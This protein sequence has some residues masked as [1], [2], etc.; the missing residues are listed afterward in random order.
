MNTPVTRITVAELCEC[1]GMSRTTLLQL[2]QYDIAAPLVGTSIDDWEFDT[3]TA[4]WMQRAV[5][6]QRDLD[7]DW[8]AVATLIDLLREREELRRENRELRQRLGRFLAED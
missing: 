6:L 5:R 2:V 1:N 7:L 3:S 8:L 4:R